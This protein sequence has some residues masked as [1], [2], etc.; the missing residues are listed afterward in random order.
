MS[1]PQ[2]PHLL[3]PNQSDTHLALTVLNFKSRDS[4]AWVWK[5]PFFH[6]THWAWVENEV[7]YGYFRKWLPLIDNNIPRRDKAHQ[8]DLTEWRPPRPLQSYL[9][10]LSLWYTAFQL[11]C[12]P[13]FDPEPPW[14][15]LPQDL[16]PSYF[17]FLES[18]FFMLS[19]GQILVFTHF[20]VQISQACLNTI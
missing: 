19:T 16:H 12:P 10:L 8:Y 17:P 2:L 20:S 5:W 14:M 11:H 7:G 18:P 13:H 9:P 1:N 6:W 15:F 4:A 3:F